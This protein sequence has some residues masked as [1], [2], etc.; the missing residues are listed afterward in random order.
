M[1]GRTL[2]LLICGAMF[3]APPTLRAQIAAQPQAP[4]PA[5][6]QAQP[7]EPAVEEEAEPRSLVEETWRQFELS[8]RFGS[9]AGD[10]ARFQRYDDIRDGLLFTKAR[11][12]REDPAGSWLFRAAADNVGWRDQRFFADYERTGRFTVSGFW[13][14]IPQFYSVDTKTPYT[15]SGGALVLD[16]ATQRAIQGATSTGDASC[17]AIHPADARLSADDKSFRAGSR[18]R[19]LSHREESAGP[20]GSALS[21]ARSARRSI[22]LSRGFHDQSDF[23]MRQFQRCPPTSPQCGLTTAWPSP[24]LSDD[25]AS[26]AV[27]CVDGIDEARRTRLGEGARNLVELPGP[28]TRAPDYPRLF[29]PR[30]SALR[31]RSRSAGLGFRPRSSGDSGSGSNATSSSFRLACSSA[32]NTFSRWRASRSSE[33]SAVVPLRRTVS[34]LASR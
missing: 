9:M 2:G 15:T 16:D 13:D 31:S 10:P 17:T 27:L 20:E 7:A 30:Q 11:Y 32:S 8:A 14:Q 26:Q 29:I 19:I 22:A 34:G 5:G 23:A 28:R 4:K 6:A 25:R 33:L 24:P 21:C 18:L 12:A 1:H 3:A